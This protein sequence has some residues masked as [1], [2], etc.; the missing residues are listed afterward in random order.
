M[1]SDDIRSTWHARQAAA[2]DSAED[3]RPSSAGTGEHT[4]PHA[5]RQ[6]TCPECGENAHARPPRDLVNW[7]AHGI[8]P[9]GW[10][11]SD[12]SS[13]CPVPGPSGGYQPAQPQPADP[14]A[15]AAQP[16][17]DI[18]AEQP[19]GWDPASG[20]GPL[21][22]SEGQL[23]DGPTG[24]PASILPG[25]PANREPV[26]GTVHAPSDRAA[27][28][29]DYLKAAAARPGVPAPQSMADPEREAG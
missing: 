16:E 10:S 11:H 17:P 15:D 1:N 13:L 23:I 19:D 4:S 7:E 2:L 6:M 29:G 24:S 20:F 3:T 18:P 8:T 28:S 21:Y 27:A 12:G 9:P 14:G 26:P 22:D 5:G 25:Q